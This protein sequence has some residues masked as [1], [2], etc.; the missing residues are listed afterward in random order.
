[1]NLLKTL[2]AWTETLNVRKPDLVCEL[3]PEQE[4]Q[5][6][7]YQ[8]KWRKIALSVTPC[9][10]PHIKSTIQATCDA[11]KKPFPN[12]IF[13]DSPAHLAYYLLP[14]QRTWGFRLYMLWDRLERQ[15]QRQIAQH[16]WL[17]LSLHDFKETARFWELVTTEPEALQKTPKLR[18][19]HLGSTF[20]RASL[21]DYCISV[22]NCRHNPE[23][24]ALFQSLVQSCSWFGCYEN[25]FLIIDRPQLLSVDEEYRLHAEGKPAVGF[26]DGFSLYAYHGVKLPER[27]GRLFP[28]QWQSQ[29]LLSEDN[30]ELRRVLL[31]GIGYARLCVELQAETLDE[32][33][34]YSLLRINSTIDIEPI[35]LLK[36]IC[37]S[38]GYCHALRVPPQMTSA[39]QAIA[40]VNWDIDP[41]EFSVQS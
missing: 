13:C 18:F 17:K 19:I 20:A 14:T 8:E 1:M 15:L 38:T 27:Y 5:I 37:P 33:Q 31:Q 23:T 34:E 3:T 12:L 36:M 6:A 41:E 28:S 29:W 10:R 40:W 26:R 35:Y 9:D 2:E 25:T 16:L 21:Y 11:L 32:W 4:L 30:V 22:L 7:I 24:W 39:R